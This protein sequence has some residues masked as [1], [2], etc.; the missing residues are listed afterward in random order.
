VDVSLLR[1]G[2]AVI[3][4]VERPRKLT[5]G[6]AIAPLDDGTVDMGTSWDF[7]GPPSR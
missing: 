7:F 5:D 4:I 6:T 2:S 1:K 3:P